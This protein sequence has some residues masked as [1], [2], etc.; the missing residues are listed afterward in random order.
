MA[1]DVEIVVGE[2]AANAYVHARTPFTVSLRCAA[3]GWRVE[4][5]DQSTELPSPRRSAGPAEEGGR[6]LMMVDAIAA[7]W[8]ACRVDGGKV[9]WADLGASP[10]ERESA[11]ETLVP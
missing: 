2:L 4:V 11:A 6:G 7:A 1:S 3:A 8:G 5:F 9:V 10:P